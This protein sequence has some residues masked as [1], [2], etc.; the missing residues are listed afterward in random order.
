[1]WSEE[2]LWCD[3]ILGN[4]KPLFLCVMAT[5]LGKP[6]LSQNNSNGYALVLLFITI[7][8]TTGNSSVI[9]IQHN[10]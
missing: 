9:Y 3:E 2:V 10:D 6:P 1:M 5:A 4:T 7:T 8:V